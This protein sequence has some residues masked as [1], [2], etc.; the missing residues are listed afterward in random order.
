MKEITLNIVR[1]YRKDKIIHTTHPECWEELTPSQFI[2][3][4]RVMKGDISEDDILVEM[5]DLPHKTVENLDLYQ[6]YTLG[7]L[8]EFI[9]NK[10][11]FNR[12]VIQDISGLKPPEDGLNDVTFGEFM[13][14]DTFYA[15]YQQSNSN[16]DLLNLVSCIYVRP[17]KTGERPEFNGRV[18]TTRVKTF[19]LLQREAIAMNYGLIRTWLEEAFPEVFPQQKEASGKPQKQSNGWIDVY[20]SIVGDDLVNAEKYF[21]MPCTEVLRYMNK[22]VKENRKKK[23]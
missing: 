12:F 3:L 17:A 23:K 11:P 13:Y 2:A 15:D 20:D 19:H 8:L 1:R 5:L 14:I 16:D 18:D 22:K 4:V 7:Q 10:A 9:Q 6:R 21:N